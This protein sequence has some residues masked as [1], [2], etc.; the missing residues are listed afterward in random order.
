ML[1]STGCGADVPL[2][3]AIVAAVFLVA[4]ILVVTPMSFSNAVSF[5]FPPP[6][7][8]LR[9]YQNYFSNPD[10]LEP[11]LSSFVIACGTTALTLVLAVP[12]AIAFARFKFRGKALINVLII[13]PMIV[14]Q[15]VSGS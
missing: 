1:V 14:P 4:P 10:W 13:S 12:A 9:Y 3:L 6:S 15:V 11:T 2:A 5:E 8:S 7:W